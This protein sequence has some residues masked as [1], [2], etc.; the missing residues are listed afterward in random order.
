MVLGFNDPV[1]VPKSVSEPWRFGYLICGMFCSI[2]CGA[3]YAFSLISGKMTD[4]YG[5]DQ[6]D[7]TTVS[8]VGIVFGYFTLPFGFIYDYIGPKPI[9][10]IGIFFFFLGSVLFALTFNDKIGHSVVSLSAINA[11]MSIGCSM[12]DMGSIL[13]ILSWFPLDRGLVVASVKTMTGLSAS[14]LATLYNTYFSGKHSTYMFFLLA[15]VV[16]IGLAAFLIL[17]IPPYHMTGYRLKH[18]T[19][20]ERELARRVEHMYHT[21]RASR[22]RFALLFVVFGGLILTIAVQSIVFVYVGKGGVPF[23]MRNPPAVVMMVLIFLFFIVVLPW[24]WLDK[25]LRRS[26][27]EMQPDNVGQEEEMDNKSL[28]GNDEL[29]VTNDDT[30]F[31]QYQTGF[32]SNVFHSIP[33]WCMWLNALV[34]NGGVTI[35]MMNSRQLYVAVSEKTD[36]EQLS[37]MFV[38]ITSIGNAVARLFVSFFEAWNASLPLEKRT[39]VTVTYCIPSL[40]LFLSSIFFIF[41]PAKALV[42][43]MVFGGFANGAYA[44]SL[45][46]TVRTIFSLDVAKHYNSIFFFDAMGSV[47][48]NRVLYGELT[49]RNS[50]KKGKAIVCLGRDKCLRTTFIVM[51]CCCA[52]SFSVCLLM[53]FLYMRYVRSR[54]EE[55]KLDA[56]AERPSIPAIDAE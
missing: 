12:F 11:I 3:I 26:S 16:A 9:F 39:P 32:I 49:T 47:I 38:A 43:P 21:K 5:F 54:R 40:L 28:P 8:T 33:L 48:F 41:L 35:I 29:L 34:V 55:N 50:V 52:L 44:A 53:H 10:V 42:L 23:S 30:N 31:P 25:P 24:R 46:L 15:F 17:R 37:A 7:I 20:E 6:N 2:V 27:R 1:T 14:I 22:R 51:S 19:E 45:V 18:Y 4:D 13:T 36:D 56:A